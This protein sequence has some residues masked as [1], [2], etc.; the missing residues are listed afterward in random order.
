MI[1]G[2]AGPPA[3][4]RI[5]RH[6]SE[7]TE[8]HEANLFSTS[9]RPAGLV[10]EPGEPIAGAA[11]VHDPLGDLVADLGDPRHDVR[12]DGLVDVRPR[13]P[14]VTLYTVHGGGNTVPGPHPAPRIIGRTTADIAAQ[15]VAQASGASERTGP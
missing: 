11:Q 4:I 15:V 6:L 1:Y 2:I 9:A 13:C 7:R 5:V 10:Q 12:A 8:A 3:T 14:P